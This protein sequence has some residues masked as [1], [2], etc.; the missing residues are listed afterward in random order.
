MGVHAHTHSSARISKL[1]RVA[2]LLTLAYIAVTVVAGIKAHSLALLSEAGQNVSDFLAL[3]LSWV[4]GYLPNRPPTATKTFGYHR[5]GVLPALVNALSLVVVALY[6][7]VEAA[8][9]IVRP[10]TLH[11][12]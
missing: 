12:R 8:H 9:P 2:L 4:A 11:A 5:A 3:L 7:F 1:L 10:I 6:I